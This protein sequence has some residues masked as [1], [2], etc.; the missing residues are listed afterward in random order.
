MR[1]DAQR[2]RE[3]LL[4]AA[5][6]LILEVGGEP[7]RDAIAS[8]AG[9]GIGTLYRHFPDQQSLL[10]AVALHVLDRT[11]T[12]GE[13]ALADS[14]SGGEALRRYMHL[15]IDHG[16]GVINII[17]PLIEHA[18]WPD[19][20][21]RAASLLLTIVD[22]AQSD[23]VMRPDATA[24]DVGFAVIRACRPLAVGLPPDEERAL[25][26]RHVDI[27][28]DGLTDTPSTPSSG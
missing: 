26:H 14:A 21:A 25:A 11:I 27:C 28:L 24:T 7:S 13:G 10:K 20:R 18:D 19:Q 12:A 3:R 1:A 2:N 4:D 17:Y 6:E 23:G 8:R 15:A 16:L 22:R 5:V 9:V